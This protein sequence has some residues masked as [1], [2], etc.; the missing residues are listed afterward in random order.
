MK[1]NQTSDE[2]SAKSEQPKPKEAIRVNVEKAFVPVFK[3]LCPTCSV[4]IRFPFDEGV[5]REFRR[6]NIMRIGCPQCKAIL[7]VGQSALI[8]PAKNPPVSN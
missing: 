6:G 2:F 7:G 8:L 1:K 4:E 5:A 3:V